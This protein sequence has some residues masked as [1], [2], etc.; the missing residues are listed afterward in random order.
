M[1][2]AVMCEK[3]KPMRKLLKVI[4]LFI[5]LPSVTIAG[6]LTTE[7][8]TVTITQQCPEG[9]VTCD[10]VKYL[11]VSKKTG[12]SIVLNGTTLHTKCA[13]GETP[14]RFL[15]YEFKNGNI[16]YRVLER[17]LLQVIKNKTEVLLEEKGTW[18]Y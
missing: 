16:T 2:A 3:E 10:K 13:D 4:F 18:S 7:N 15:G 11:G 14:C 6:T 8:Y 1:M 17:G 9:H 5:S 12:S